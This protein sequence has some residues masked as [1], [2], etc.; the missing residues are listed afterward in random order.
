MWLRYPKDAPERKHWKH[1]RKKTAMLKVLPSFVDELVKLSATAQEKA[2]A[3]FASAQ[4]DWNSF[5]K[6]LRSQPFR[7]AVM[8]M[9]QSDEKLRKYVKNFGAYVSGKDV[10]AE[11]KSKDS[12][13]TYRIKDLHNGRMGCNCRD[14]Q[15]TH[16]VKGGDCK[17]IKSLKASNLVKKASP[18]GAAFTAVN[19]AQRHR[20][21]G[22]KSKAALTAVY[23]GH[24]PKDS[25]LRELVRF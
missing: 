1:H 23:G 10:I 25:F 14:W 11:L 9:A 19:R 20:E 6:N 4:P 24:Q 17:H 13:R 7:D 15:F 2:E 5:T 16:S 3:H 22:K 8:R 21:E 12:G 18:F